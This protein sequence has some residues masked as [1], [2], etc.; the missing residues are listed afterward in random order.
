MHPRIHLVQIGANAAG[1]GELNEW[2]RPVLA[3]NPLWTAT[4]VEPVPFLYELLV[5]NYRSMRGRVETMRYAVA[6][7]TGRCRMM[8]AGRSSRYKQVRRRPRTLW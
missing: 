3:E 7:R 4:V 6:A 1:D 2:V 8:A 5:H